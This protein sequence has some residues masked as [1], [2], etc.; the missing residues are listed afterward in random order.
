[1]QIDA[2]KVWKWCTEKLMKQN[3]SK[4][5][6]LR[7]KGEAKFTVSGWEFGK[8]ENEKGL[9]VMIHKDLNRTAR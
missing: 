1:M 6:V 5:K 3:V 8:P 9:G 4:C 7:I 2:A